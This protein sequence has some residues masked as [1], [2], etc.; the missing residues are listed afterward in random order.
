MNKSMVRA[1]AGFA[2][3][4]AAVGSSSMAQATNVTLTGWAHGGGGTVQVSGTALPGSLGGSY[5]GW[6][7]AFR[8][9]LSGAQ[10]LDSLSF[11]TWCIELEESFSF[12]STA[13]TGY[14]VMGAVDYFNDRQAQNPL[15]PDGAQVADRLGRLVT[16]MN[17]DPTR[18]DSATESVAMQLAIWNVVYD[19]DWSLSAAGAQRTPLADASPH[20]ALATQMLQAAAG[21]HSRYTVYALTRAGKQDFLAYTLAVPEPGSLALAALALLALTGTALQRGRRSNA[22]AAASSRA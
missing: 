18:V 2:L 15:R 3:A 11:V 20:Q 1:L 13:M 5:N 14:R 9:S 6:A 19:S 21:V 10:G 16:W 8:G 7:G 17:T 12:S 4:A 22:A